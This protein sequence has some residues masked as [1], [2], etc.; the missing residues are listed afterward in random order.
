[1]S[2]S[3][4]T[5]IDDLF[6]EVEIIYN[7]LYNGR[8]ERWMEKEYTPM[9]FGWKHI[10]SFI[11][12]ERREDTIDENKKNLRDLVQILQRINSDIEMVFTMLPRYETMEIIENKISSSF[13]KKELEDEVLKICK[14]NFCNYFSQ[15]R[16][17][18]KIFCPERY[19]KFFIVAITLPHWV[20]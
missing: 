4:G 20:L 17:S 9:W 6:D 3:N 7:E 8:M 10:L 18:F 1:M 15:K 5:V 11:R 12:Q 14:E 13:W 2:D 16:L 19:E